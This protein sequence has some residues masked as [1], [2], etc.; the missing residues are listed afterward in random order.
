M[1]QLTGSRPAQSELM[2]TN[3]RIES[4]SDGVIYRGADFIGA[5]TRSGL[6]G[7]T[8]LR[9]IAHIVDGLVKYPRQ[10]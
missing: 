6:V 9:G 3:R 8:L 10:D 2:P 1:R 4:F 7:R 5:E